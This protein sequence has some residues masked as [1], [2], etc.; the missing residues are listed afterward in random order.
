MNKYEI[1]FEARTNDMDLPTF[2]A[3]LRSLALPDCLRPAIIRG[4]YKIKAHHASSSK[5]KTTD[6]ADE[7]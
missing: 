1:V 7:V 3:W 5:Y 6:R 4:P 2:Q